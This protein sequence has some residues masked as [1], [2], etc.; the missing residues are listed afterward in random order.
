[1]ST[2]AA[3]IE[4]ALARQIFRGERRLGETLPPVRAL[5]VQF[6]VTVPTIQ[7]AIDRLA[8]TGLV[9]VR[10]GSGI[11]VNDPLRLGD[12]S[13]VGALLEACADQTERVAPMLADF[14]ELRRILATQL[15]RT[16]LDKLLEAI[17]TMLGPV[18]RLTAATELGEVAAADADLTRIVV[19]AAGNTAVNAVFYAIERLAIRVPQV[20]EA[21]YGD[22]AAHQAAVAGVVAALMSSE[23]DAARAAEGVDA[24][25]GAWDAGSVARFR[26]AGA[27]TGAS[28]SLS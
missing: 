4:Q 27:A 2:A 19:E 25:L 12:L 24:V 20:A 17:P 8:A 3:R 21:V 11:T 26:R 13:V 9:T 6:A 7:R 15:I 1:M 23:G 16:R 10:Q 14:L 22:R 5:A 28:P 18:Q